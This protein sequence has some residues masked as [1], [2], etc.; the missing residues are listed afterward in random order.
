MFGYI[1]GWV[2]RSPSK[3]VQQ[4]VKS[5]LREKI[6]KYTCTHATCRIYGFAAIWSSVSS[7]EARKRSRVVYMP[8]TWCIS[9][10]SVRCHHRA[11]MLIAIMRWFLPEFLFFPV[12]DRLLHSCTFINHAKTR[13]YCML[14]KICHCLVKKDVHFML[15]LTL[16]CTYINA[17]Q[18]CLSQF[19]T[20][21]AE[22]GGVKVGRSNHVL[23][24][25]LFFVLSPVFLWR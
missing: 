5:G 19:A 1:Q 6:N 12:G 20:D 23:V 17:S 4:L 24:F 22:H 25:L 8:H 16:V 21:K 3:N 2:G 18:F 9:A 10:V 7:E 13:K 15:L 11:S 14:E